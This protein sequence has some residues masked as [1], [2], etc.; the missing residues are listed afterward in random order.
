MQTPIRI[1]KFIA[2][3]GFCSRRKAEEFIELQLVKVNGEIVTN[4]ATH[5]TDADLIKID[6]K[7]LKK[8][9][10]QARLW[11]YH[12]PTGLITSHKDTH[13]RATVFETLPKDLP[14]VVSVG[15]LDLNSE[16]LLLLT[17]SGKLARY[18]ELPENA[19]ERVYKVRAY[20]DFDLKAIKEIEKGV[21]I[22]S[23]QYQP[24]K[25]ELTKTGPNS[26]FEVILSEGKNREIRKIFS[27][28]NLEVNRLL[29]IKYGFFA[30]NDLKPGEVKEIPYTELE[31][32][33]PKD[34]LEI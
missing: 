33:L 12:K 27:H 2:Q 7:L 3:S 4:P 11:L 18:F 29:R 34:L 1:A 6:G 22:D 19:I 8:V 15:R 13:G 26:W 30:L 24:A 10:S 25:I 31:K 20:G 32:I 14:R 28:F 16:G 17:N 23:V 5:V 9:A 21:V